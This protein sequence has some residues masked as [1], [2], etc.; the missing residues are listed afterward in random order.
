MIV[1]KAYPKSTMTDEEEPLLKSSEEKEGAEASLHPRRWWCSWRNLKF[2]LLPIE[3]CAFLF[4]FAVYFNVQVYQQYLYQRI[5][6]HEIDVFNNVTT[7][8][9]DSNFE[10]GIICLDQD[11]IT[12]LSSQA[13][14]LKGQKEVNRINMITTLISLSL[15]LIASLFLVPYSDVF[16]RKPF[17]A[18]VFLGQ[19]AG[20]VISL[21]IVY[22]NLNMYYFI[23][24]SIA[25][26]LGGSFGIMLAA[27]S[28][29][30]TDITPPRWLAVR[31]AILGGVIFV[32]SAS[33]S[34]AS[35]KWIQTTNCDFRPM[36]W[37]ILGTVLSGLVFSLILPE[38]LNSDVKS[39]STQTSRKRGIRSLIRGFKIFTSLS[40]VSPL[41][42]LKLWITA[43]ITVLT[44][45]NETGGFEIIGYFLHN[46]PLEWDYTTIGNY[47]AVSSVA[48]MLALII[49]LPLL[50]VAK[51]PNTVIISI[52]IAFALLFNLLIAAVVKKT[53]EM[54][55]GI[56]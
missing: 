41:T 10:N 5:M 55:L 2:I 26:G 30:V 56:L 53:W 51:F 17:L 40:Y 12:N 18:L 36:I 15:S 16:G 20:T 34:S 33:A 21:I 35:D 22:F 39:K 31:M 25:N 49:I 38:S 47:I 23:L 42:L 19:A 48:H 11:T 4:L 24:S 44:L 50:V 13:M 54:F 8:D 45:I 9:K 7:D 43:G 37:L 3:V 1:K 29:Y 32:G 28:A 27:C 6:K 46:K 52:G 14:F